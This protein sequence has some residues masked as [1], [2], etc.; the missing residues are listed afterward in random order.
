MAMRGFPTNFYAPAHSSRPRWPGRRSEGSRRSSAGP[1]LRS[2]PARR[3]LRAVRPLALEGASTILERM[4]EYQRDR[5]LY[6]GLSGADVRVERMGIESHGLAAAVDA[7]APR[8]ARVKLVPSITG[9][10]TF[11][12]A[13][14]IAPR[15]LDH[16]G[17][18]EPTD[19]RSGCHDMSSMPDF[20]AL[21][22]SHWDCFLETTAVPIDA[23]CT[24]FPADAWEV[25]LTRPAA[26]DAIALLDVPAGPGSDPPVVTVLDGSGRVVAPPSPA[27]RIWMVH[28]PPDCDLRLRVEAGRR[29]V[30]VAPPGVTA[31]FIPEPYVET[32]SP[33]GV[34]VVRR[35]G[36]TGRAEPVL[37]GEERRTRASDLPRL[38]LGFL[39]LF[40]L[41]EGIL[42]LAYRGEAGPSG[43]FRLALAWLLGA[44]SAAVVIDVMGAS[45]LPHGRWILA[46]L[47]MLALLG[48][49]LRRTREAS[50]PA[51][52][53][54]SALDKAMAWIAGGLVA[55]TFAHAAI[56]P[57]IEWD[58]LMA[59]GYRGHLFFHSGATRGV[60]ETFERLRPGYGA[61][62]PLVPL[63]EAYVAMA[64]GRWDDGFVTTPAAMAFGAMIALLFAAVRRR[65]SSG[66]AGF[67]VVLGACSSMAMMMAVA[68]LADL[69]LAALFVAA[70][71]CLDRWDPATGRG[72]VIAAGLCCS[73][74]AL[75]KLEGG[76]LRLL[77]LV[78]VVVRAFRHRSRGAIAVAIFLA[79]AFLPELPWQLQCVRS[80]LLDSNVS[81][82][83]FSPARLR[84]TVWILEPVLSSLARYLFVE[85]YG[86]ETHWNAT[87]LVLVALLLLGPR[88]LLRRNLLWTAALAF[89]LAGYVAIYLVTPW[90]VPHM[91]SSLDRLLLHLY[92]VAVVLAGRATACIQTQT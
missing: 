91:L 38:L 41:G 24:V 20:V 25:P 27:G 19:E 48:F 23:P 79:C 83:D 42:R 3:P 29:P 73:L 43:L 13:S 76:P 87:Y 69:P 88:S 62:P 63:V 57:M 1:L 34:L 64:V 59:W 17:A 10:E 37:P 39:L 61:Y 33:P 49:T 56:R 75:T 12:F 90:G 8:D 52:T 82:H 55:M 54:M 65:A 50:Q 68:G 4:A 81:A 16:E 30:T 45:G 67:V 22:R 84:A 70:V 58:A 51:R 74:M 80:G 89:G 72:D 18:L 71:A 26:A 31:R 53:P 92:P 5:E 11:S 36:A 85:G 2:V 21:P 66:L 46:M 78:L 15:K 6:S 9:M 77:I 28:L 14:A 32:S 7:L 35:S 40:A 47:A 60:L 86:S 44:G